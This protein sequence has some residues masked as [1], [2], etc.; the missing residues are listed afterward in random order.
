[1]QAFCAREPSLLGLASHVKMHLAET[2]FLFE[3]LEGALQNPVYLAGFRKH[4]REGEQCREPSLLGVEGRPGL[5]G[6]QSFCVLVHVR[7]P[8]D[9][10]RAV[11]M[12]ERP[13]LL[14]L[15]Y[16]RLRAV[17]HS[18]LSSWP[19]GMVERPSLLGLD[20]IRLRAVS[21]VERQTN[22]SVGKQKLA[23]PGFHSGPGRAEGPAP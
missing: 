17:S 16:I 6:V 18:A 20:Y 7:E 19:K 12:V 22:V 8:F 2:G 10:L 9:V 3:H 15:D 5:L 1:M 4:P 13:S 21:M 23:V 11:S 14:G